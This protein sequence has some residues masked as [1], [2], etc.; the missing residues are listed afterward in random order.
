MT[1]SAVERIRSFNRVVTLGV[2]AL[3]DSYL[4]RGRPL[5]EARLLFEIGEDGAPAGALRTALGL[6][7]GYFSRIVR[8]LARQGLV[9]VTPDPADRRRRRLALTAA[10]R[11]E[12]AAYDALSDDLAR[13]WLGGLDAGEQA[14]LVAA[15]AEVET[16]MTAARVTIAPEPIDGAAARACLAAYFAELAA[17][18]EAGFDPDAGGAAED[19][20]MTPPDGCFLV[21]RIDGRPVGCGALKPLDAQTAEIKRMWVA[22]EARGRGL[23]RRLLAALEAEARARNRHRVRLDTNRALTTAQAMYRKAGYRPIAR[24]N[25]NP[26]ADFWFEKT[27]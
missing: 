6:D 26:Y 17:R 2:G 8:S 27:L 4:G 16:L 21:A 15:M 23:A 9:A 3:N 1:Q 10:G 5:G 14:R 19:A 25:D 18:F 7:S 11:A 12:R 22:P 13:A 20:A 24:F